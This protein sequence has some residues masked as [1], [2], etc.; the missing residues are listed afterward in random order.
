MRDPEPSP[1]SPAADRRRAA[2]RSALERTL[3]SWIR[4]G[5]ALCALGFVILRLGYYLEELARVNG[6]SLPP[7]RASIPIGM[8]HLFIG[9]AI[10]I[11]AALWHHHT[12]RRLETGGPDARWPARYVVIAMTVGSVIGGIALAVDLLLSWPP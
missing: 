2:D 8:L 12:A 11:F 4:T 3:L 7:G 10:V 5:L 1:A 6:V 9:V